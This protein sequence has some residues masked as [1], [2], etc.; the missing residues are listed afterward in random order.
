MLPPTAYA[1]PVGADAPPVAVQ[2]DQP[3]DEPVD[4]ALDWSNYERVLL[5]QDTGEPIG[6]AVMPDL[7][8]LHTARSG[9]I[10]HTDPETG[11]TEVV[12]TIDVYA[13][14]EDGLQNLVLDP[15][16][17]ENGW[18]Y[19]FYAP[20]VMEGERYPETTPAGSS[21]TTLPE[22]EDESSY[23]DQWLG[24]NQLSRIQWDAEAGALDM[25]TEQKILQVEVQRGQCCH[26]AG[27]IDFDLDGN[28]LLAT[29]DNTPAGAVGA[30]GFAPNNDAPGVAP[31]Q[32]AR[33]GAGNTNDLRGKILRIT[34]QENGSYT[35]P[36]GNLWEPGGELTRDEVYVHGLRNPFRMA[37]DPETGA[38]SWADYGPD[39][40]VESP[41]RGPM[42]YVEW[43]STTVPMNGGWPFCH[44][45]N[46]DYNNWDFEN[47]APREFF[48]CTAGATNDS[49]W[50]TGLVE[51]PPATAPQLHYGDNPGDQPWDDLVTF[52]TQSGQG[53]MGGP[54][55]R[56]DESI[57]NEGQLP[58]YWDGKTFLYEFS[59]DYV[60]AISLAELEDGTVDFDGEVTD[61]ENFLPNE[62][63]ETNN[64][65]PWSG[66]IDME[67]GPD[68]AMYVLDYGKGFFRQNPTAGLYRVEYAP[69]NKR[70]VAVATA[71]PDSGSEAPLTVELDGSGSYDPEGEDIT[72]AWDLD[73]D[74]ETDATTPTVEHTFEELG[75]YTVSLRVTD[76]QGKSTATTVN[77]TVGN[78]SPTLTLE[79]PADGGF[80]AWGDNVPF[81]Y[82]ATDV[83]DGPTI[84]C[85]RLNWTFGLGHDTHAHPL[86]QRVNLCEGNFNTPAEAV[87]HGETEKLFGVIVAGYTDA[88]AGDIPP[89][90]TELT[91]LLNTFDKEAEHADTFE[92]V[93]VVADDSAR[94][95]SK[96]VYG[97]GGSIA[98]NTVN[99]V[100]IDGATG[101]ASGEGTVELRWGSADAEPFATAEVSSPEWAEFTFTG[102]A[103]ADLVFPTGTGAVHVTATAGLEL[104]AIDFDGVG[105][106]AIHQPEPEPEPLVEIPV[107][108]VSIGM[109][110]LVPWLN[111]EGLE[112]VLTRLSEI[113]FEN[114]EPFG[115]NFSGYSAQEFR[116]LTDG[117]G[118]AVPTSHYNVEEGTFDATLEYVATL[119]QEYVGSGGFAAPGITTYE[120]T[121]ETAA[122][123]NRLGARS[124]E[125]GVGKFFGHNHAV[126]FTTEHTY[127]EHADQTASAWE[128][129]VE[130]T[131][132]DL[133][134]FQV[135]VAWAAHA[136]VDVVQLLEEHG[137]RIELLHIKDATNL[138]VGDPTF[139]NL[140]E[141][142]VPLQDI[143]RK[144]EEVGVEYYTIEYDRAAD[145][146]GFASAGFEY[147]TGIP[148]GGGT[149]PEPSSVTANVLGTSHGVLEPHAHDEGGHAG[150]S[151]TASA[152]ADN[153]I[154]GTATMVKTAEGT[155]V[156]V[157]AAGLEPDTEYPSHLHGGQC[158][159][160][161]GHYQNDPS[162]PMAPPN[163]I[164]VS[165]TD[166]VR[167]GL[168][169]DAEG[170]ASG[171]GSA[172]WV[173]RQVP[174]S[175]MI[176][177]S[178]FPGMPVS[179]ADF[180][181]YDA[182]ATVV[183]DGGDAEVEYSVNDGEWATY[184][185]PFDVTEAGDYTVT[186][187]E[188]DEN[189]ETTSI[190]RID[191][192]VVE[193]GDTD[194]ELVQIP[195]EQVSMGM[196]SL[197]NWANQIG[198]PN[199]ME[200]LSAIGFENIEPFGSTL[201]GYEA[202]DFRDLA[203]SLGLS[204]PSS[205]YN[206]A[207]NTFD[208]T[209][210]Y[211][212]TLGQEYV[213]SG[214][215]A[216]PG[217]SSYENTLA[218]AA[219]M[220]RLGERSVE[221]GVGKFFGHNHAGEFTTT[222][223][224]EGEVQSAWEILVAETDAE[225]VTFQV[226]VAWAAHAGVDVV[227][228]LEEHGDRIELLHVKDA[229]NLGGSV[230]PTF[231]NLGQGD[232]PLQ[233]IL[234][235]GQETGVAYYVTEFD[236][237]PANE[238]FSTQGFEYLTGLEAGEIGPLTP[239]TPAA[240]EFTAELGAAGTYTV[241]AVE[242]VEYLVSNAVVEAGTY[243]GAG[244]VTV[245]ARP[246]L[247]FEFTEGATRQWAFTFS[248]FLD[249]AVDNL[250]F[251]EIEWLANAGISTGWATPAGAEFRPLTPIARDAMAAFLYRLADSPEFDAPEVS[252]FVDVPT[253]NMF[254][255]EI[256]WLADQDIS[257]GWVTASGAEFRP[258]DPIGRDAMAAFLYRMADSPEFDAPETSPFTDVTPQTQFYAEI[259]WLVD[260]GIATGWLGNDG[261]A[262]YQ[263]VAPIA[264]DAMAAFLA[265]FHEAGYS[266]I[267]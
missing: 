36:A 246:T 85:S 105:V 238:V 131:D 242:G 2:E 43:Q 25:A 63:L 124:V 50:N 153:G 45:P 4:P 208:A 62:D 65:A 188:T 230:N 133:V 187:R 76:P 70:P 198:W 78:S 75:Q 225:H 109:F 199:V 114:V 115:S 34:V 172:D 252:P 183:V 214:G 3:A 171:Q 64:Q 1:A 119:G 68:G 130:H 94:A 204:I 248:P 48:H 55:F 103:G 192:S 11:I 136:G 18:V 102:P 33:R 149:D 194:P 127:G 79:Y 141:G 118:L 31:G 240:V 239:V 210:E 74:G 197:N 82:T 195:V 67:I 125:A 112:P 83:E 148:A 263:P 29:G 206:T 174:L 32:D 61:I 12:N 100:G 22:G 216:A 215:F 154:T 178:V 6:L 144:A 51:Q 167:G 249:V 180:S 250:F 99:F 157:D 116:A 80:F 69:E 235:K 266:G 113:G 224:H 84:A 228:L 229:T 159:D 231:V 140:G 30:N 111:D 256:A 146:E 223:E 182:P 44:G 176:H 121:L 221:A 13:N 186:Y 166:D 156:T 104:D 150:H 205:H 56:Y 181:A 203:D 160:M 168:V 222:Y 196:F 155:T 88:G 26:V 169:S 15:D 152:A 120:S 8:V 233:D 72:Y 23:W 9:E 255:K 53:P 209:L 264:R 93:E 41:D 37:V 42:G 98:W 218:T 7:T 207:E 202:Q 217:I 96:V 254:Y 126:E 58:E 24:Y 52:T 77:V 89:A 60:A 189:D 117:L 247:G 90:R 227:E 201:R 107:E 87:E 143:L 173:A 190:G 35:I 17:A 21:P 265:R 251:T 234:A 147:L 57:E 220:N 66:P 95:F 236:G 59:Q 106:G 175:V 244:T 219:T 39:S 129:L 245:T 161:G 135:D 5:T 151:G 226:D 257:T 262:M 184:D 20:R 97:D 91:T 165:S 213:G 259:T 71:T 54:T 241:P 86:E 122:T 92:G 27:D 267:E 212:S 261:T 138:G 49:R 191:F 170:N 47:S 101:S 108:Q 177:E 132:E 179:C 134:T 258:L 142:E 73:A 185:G 162:G 260:E 110:S 243:P 123:M 40:A 14:S 81:K 16:F 28:L 19:L 200:R 137:E 253:S 211:V 158:V 232:V 46:S 128:L 38:L 163:E 145:G 164:W 237:S 139:V 10:R 193:G